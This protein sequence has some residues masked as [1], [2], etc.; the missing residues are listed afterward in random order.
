MKYKLI[1]SLMVLLV[2]IIPSILAENTQEVTIDGKKVILANVGSDGSIMINVNGIIAVVSPSTTKTLEGLEITNLETYYKDTKAERSAKIMIKGETETKEV[3]LMVYSQPRNE[4]ALSAGQGIT[5]ADKYEI[6]LN[7]V[8]SD[9][10][11]MIDVNGIIAVIP[12]S[13]VKLVNGAEIT[14]LETLYMTTKAYR[15]A[16]I[17]VIPISEPSTPYKIPEGAEKVEY[18][19]QVST[20]PEKFIVKCTSTGTINIQN[21]VGEL[22]NYPEPYVING[23]PN[24]LR[25]VVGDTAPASDT[26]AAI[27]IATNLQY[28]QPTKADI[29]AVLASEVTNPK[30]YNLI[31]VGQ[32]SLNPFIESIPISTA[33]IKAIPNGNNVALIV[34]GTTLLETRFAAKVLSNYEDYSLSGDECKITGEF[35]PVPYPTPTPTPKPK[36]GCISNGICEPEYGETLETC[37]KDCK[38]IKVPLQCNGCIKDESCLDFGIRVL[39]G[40]TPQYCDLDKI[41]HL[42]KLA[43]EVCQNN[44]ECKSNLCINSECISEGLWKKVMNWFSKMFG[45]VVKE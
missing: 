32:P 12:A 34:T 25:I 3:I 4:Y 39:E 7:N 38:E 19:S 43:K 16:K 18:T 5:V 10:S 33:M 30:D 40:E 29:N 42:Q 26:L 23:E 24:K 20:F 11:V 35:K 8:G 27:D 31:L 9:G 36:Y 45:Y 13:A 2:L 17:R 1:T 37:P 15:A 6:T 28:L 22:S 21:W 44:F 14:N 41:F